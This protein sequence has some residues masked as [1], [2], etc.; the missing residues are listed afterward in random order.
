MVLAV[1]A[2]LIVSVDALFIGIALGL[3]KK[4]KFVYLVMISAFLLGLCVM[5]FLVAGHMYERI[6][7]DPD[8]VVGVTFIVFGLWI[9]LH[10]AVLERVRRRRGKNA[11]DTASTR[12]IAVVGLV[13]SL[14]AMLITMGLTVLF[15]PY[16]TWL[17][18]ATVAAAHFAYAT[19]TFYLA[20][21]KR[22]QQLSLAWTHAISGFALIIYGLMALF[23]DFNVVG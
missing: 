8:V 11:D 14:E 5:G 10:Y 13:M 19:L 1:V 18:P 20:R 16:A 23:V 21:M 7:F 3:Q 2:G 6:P 22:L 17:V 15:I 9:M 4:C 12:T